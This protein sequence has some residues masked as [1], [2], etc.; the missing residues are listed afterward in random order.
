[1]E[2]VQSRNHKTSNFPHSPIWLLWLNIGTVSTINVVVMF[3]NIFFVSIAHCFKRVSPR[4]TSSAANASSGTRNITLKIASGMG[5]RRR[6][7]VTP[8][9]FWKIESF[10]FPVVFLW[11]LKFHLLNFRKLF[12]FHLERSWLHILMTRSFHH[13]DHQR[14]LLLPLILLHQ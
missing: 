6:K 1:M 13:C 10:R 2:D 14:F 7:Y 12:Q 4:S 5:V 11:N 9:I 3:S 8:S